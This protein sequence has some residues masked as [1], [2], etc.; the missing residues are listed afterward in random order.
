MYIEKCFTT[1]EK[2][3]KYVIVVINHMIILIMMVDR[4]RYQSIFSI[5]KC[6]PVKLYNYHTKEISVICIN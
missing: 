5:K 3:K 6:N 4:H 1:L 2:W